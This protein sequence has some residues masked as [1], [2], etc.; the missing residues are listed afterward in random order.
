MNKHIWKEPSA[1]RLFYRRATAL[2]KAKLRAQD[3]EF[4]NL[5]EQKLNELIRNEQMRLLKR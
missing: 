4:Q 1:A 5:W 2:K 3:P